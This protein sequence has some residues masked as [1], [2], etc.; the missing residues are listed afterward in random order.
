[1][2]EFDILEVEP[3]NGH[4]LIKV[5]L[6]QIRKELNLPSDTR[7]ELPE[8]YRKA[9]AAASDKGVIIKMAADAFGSEYKKRFG[10]DTYTPKVGQTVLFTSYQSRKLDDNGEYYLLTDDSI[11]FVL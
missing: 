7:L 2:K 6:A 11:K 3:I 8:S 5:D 4:I 1:M 10:E 9:I